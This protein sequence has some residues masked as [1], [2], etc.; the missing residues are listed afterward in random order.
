[1]ESTR[2]EYILYATGLEGDFVLGLAFEAAIPFSEMRAQA[3]MLAKRLTTTH[4]D[5]LLAREDI[6]VNKLESDAVTSES[7][8]EVPIRINSRVDTFSNEEASGIIESIGDETGSFIEGLEGREVSH[9]T[10]KESTGQS[11][12][13]VGMASGPEDHEEVQETGNE[14]VGLDKEIDLEFVSDQE[15]ESQFDGPV[16]LAEEMDDIPLSPSIAEKKIETTQPDQIMKNDLV[17]GEPKPEELE[18]DDLF[19]RYYERKAVSRSEEP[20]PGWERFGG[21]KS[22]EAILNFLDEDS[23]LTATNEIVYSCVLIPRLPGHTLKGDLVDFLKRWVKLHSIAC[24]WRL[25][26][27]VVQRDYLHWVGILP[28]ELAPG[29][30]TESLRTHSSKAIFSEFP[31]LQRENP[32]GDFWARGSYIKSGSALQEQSLIDFL[33]DI[34]KKQGLSRK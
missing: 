8:E 13:Q 6:K 33:E 22:E 11:E 17:D 23:D 27:L 32:S 14:H 10:E 30:M 21:W 4:G 7:S 20:L 25:G 24:G 12:A 2:R 16:S 18:W 3:V 31:R 5:T 26:Q 19:E 34:R 15:K 9:L 28:P 1:L 29:K